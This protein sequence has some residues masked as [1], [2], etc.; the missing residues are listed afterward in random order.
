M[1]RW[2]RSVVSMETSKPHQCVVNKEKNDL[3]VAPC[4]VSMEGGVQRDE[5]RKE[6]AGEMLQGASLLG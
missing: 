4:N 2:K 5:V 1:P 3:A 6:V